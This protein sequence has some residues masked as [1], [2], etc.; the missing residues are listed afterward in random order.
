MGTS[1]RKPGRSCRGILVL[2]RPKG[3]AVDIRRGWVLSLT[4]LVTSI[5]ALGVYRRGIFFFLHWLAIAALSSRR[6]AFSPHISR[7]RTKAGCTCT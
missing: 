6:P 4:L 3:T 2:L 1:G 5:T 7:Y